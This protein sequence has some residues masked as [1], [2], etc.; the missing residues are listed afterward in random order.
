MLTLWHAI[1]GVLVHIH[2]GLLR[3]RLGCA[4]L[5]PTVIHH[6]GVARKIGA[7]H[8]ASY[9]L[10]S[11]WQFHQSSL[12][13]CSIGWLRAG[14]P[15]ESSLLPVIKQGL[16][17]LLL[18]KISKHLFAPCKKTRAKVF[19]AR[20]TD[21]GLLKTS[22]LGG[23]E[24]VSRRHDSMLRKKF[25]ISIVHYVRRLPGDKSNLLGHQTSELFQAPSRKA[26]G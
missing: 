21:M 15:H 18:A 8:I 11:G 20:G 3:Q 6:A 4:M 16:L 24:P 22:F 7:A 13:T 1:Q 9:T 26:G 19:G 17:L 2:I 10:D 23:N 12:F 25:L 14:L 5:L